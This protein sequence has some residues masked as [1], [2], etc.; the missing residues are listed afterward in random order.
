MNRELKF[1][2]TGFVPK[3][4]CFRS[5]RFIYSRVFRRTKPQS[6][7]LLRRISALWA[8]PS[9]FLFMRSRWGIVRFSA[10]TEFWRTTRLQLPS[11]LGRRSRQRHLISLTPQRD[12]PR[13]S[14]R[15]NQQR[16][17]PRKSNVQE[18]IPFCRTIQFAILFSDSFR[19]KR[20]GGKG[21]TQ[22]TLNAITEILGYIN[23]KK[24]TKH[25][26]QKKGA[27]PRLAKEL[28]RRRAQSWVNQEI[29]R[30]AHSCCAH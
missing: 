23:Q 2:D 14:P 28:S 10:R 13:N 1:P 26:C 27:R 9:G 30:E 29:I 5:Y 6:R 3:C 12:E 16:D 7:A 17:R 15:E 4:G 21:P 20:P 19:S 24:N 18:I 11:P 8:G 22:P 25:R